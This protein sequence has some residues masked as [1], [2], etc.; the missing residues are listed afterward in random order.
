M[1]TRL[2]AANRAAKLFRPECCVDEVEELLIFD[3]PTIVG[4]C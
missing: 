3:A 4:C 2:F 1:M